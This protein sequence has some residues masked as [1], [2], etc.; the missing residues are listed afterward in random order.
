[1]PEDKAGINEN[2]YKN[3]TAPFFTSVLNAF[4]LPQ[5]LRVKKI[6]QRIRLTAA[7]AD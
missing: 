2:A 1:M 4:R 7:A 5:T 3:I 6:A